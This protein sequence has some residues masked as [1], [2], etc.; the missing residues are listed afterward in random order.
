M[1]AEVAAR[2]RY[3]NGRARLDEL[4]GSALRLP[5][6]RLARPAWEIRVRTIAAIRIGITA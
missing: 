1:G 2:L 3:S 5:M 4:R 6:R